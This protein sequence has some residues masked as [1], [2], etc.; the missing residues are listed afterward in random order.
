M[1]VISILYN[2]ISV[3]PY[4]IWMYYTHTLYIFVVM[5][6]AR[7][8]MPDD[9]SGSRLH[10]IICMLS[11]TSKPQ[12]PKKTHHERKR[13]SNITCCIHDINMH[14][15]WNRETWKIYISGTRTY[16]WYW[17]SQRFPSVF[18]SVSIG[19]HWDFWPSVSS[20]T[21]AYLQWFRWK[22]NF[23]KSEDNPPD[24]FEL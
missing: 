12:R 14:H 21:D 24:F 13:V 22:M 19:F 9:Q 7:G 5:F 8:L 11:G 16:H 23:Q 1:F 3:L 15:I 4:R 6:P 2:C 10:A 18:P 20:V 17:D